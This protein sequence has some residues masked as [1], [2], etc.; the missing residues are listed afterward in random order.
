ME[1]KS[2]IV[3]VMTKEKGGFP[4]MGFGAA[5]EQIA[6]EKTSPETIQI[7]DKMNLTVPLEDLK[8][9]H[10]IYEKIA[11][12]VDGDAREALI[13][14]ETYLRGL[15]CWKYIFT[16]GVG[17]ER[18]NEKDSLYFVM[19]SGLSLRLKR[20]ELSKGIKSVIQ[21]FMELV[22][23]ENE[24]YQ[25][26]SFEPKIGLTTMEYLTKDIYDFQ[27]GKKEISTDWQSKITLGKN[28]DTG[29]I[30]AIDPDNFAKHNGSPVNYIE[31]TE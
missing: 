3:T 12:L 21:P 8:L 6:K 1:A 17:K 18:N 26:V 31:K 10:E 30:V 11:G 19:P 2:Y 14:I 7:T 9:V 16:T 22:C 4:D 15:A 24:K 20:S 25:I 23:F 28:A 29:E 5:I 13:N 27:T